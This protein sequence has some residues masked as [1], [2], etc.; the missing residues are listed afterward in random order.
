M[1]ESHGSFSGGFVDEICDGLAQ[2]F[3]RGS[4]PCLDINFYR[5]AWAHA[6]FD[7]RAQLTHVHLHHVGRGTQHALAHTVRRDGAECAFKII[8]SHFAELRDA[9]ASRHAGAYEGDLFC[10]Q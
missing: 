7:L 3:K 9:H 5:H 8:E 6:F 1:I 4:A 2:I 10:G